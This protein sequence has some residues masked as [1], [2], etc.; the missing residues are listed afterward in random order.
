MPRLRTVLLVYICALNFNGSA[1]RAS[2]N[3][4][5]TDG[6][7]IRKADA[8][9]AGL[10]RL[11]EASATR[12]FG[13][14]RK[15]IEK[16]Y[17]GLFV[18]I[19][20]LR[21]GDLKTD[22]ATAAAL[23]EAASRAR[24]DAGTAAP[25]CSHELRD[26]Y[27]RLCRETGDDRTRLLWTKARL[28]TCWAESLLRYGRGDRSPETLDA[29]ARIRAERSIDR[30]LSE[31]AV[32]VL[33]ELASETDAYAE[34]RAAT[35]ADSAQRLSEGFSDSLAE[36]ERILDSLPRDHV[37]QLLRNAGDAFR[38]GLF[39]QS[40]TLRGR[41]LVV[42]ANSFD[43]PDTLRQIGLDADTAGRAAL[44]NRRVALRFIRKAE[45]ALAASQRG[46]V[47]D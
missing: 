39:W 34:E 27:F 22:L 35:A 37:R 6:K 36:V 44:S 15:T 25:D 18:S 5:T 47:E 3:D 41:A 7:E 23:Y 8:I 38:D 17:P 45:E 13:L 16:L 12:D 24:L 31:E 42:S 14:Y 2:A 10:H 20:N 33:K 46:E 9:V 32:R 28:H 11:E 4:P 1:A 29:L 30:M 19:S 26:S 21:D 40:K 43:A